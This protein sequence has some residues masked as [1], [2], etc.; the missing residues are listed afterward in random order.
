MH[1][2]LSVVKIYVP[3][4]WYVL[5]KECTFGPQVHKRSI[6]FSGQAHKCKI[7]DYEQ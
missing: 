2:S 3:T 6:D 1:L 4:R 7:G 5:N